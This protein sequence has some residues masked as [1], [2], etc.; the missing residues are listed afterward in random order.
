MP[1]V[2]NIANQPD[3]NNHAF[4]ITPNL[5]YSDTGNIYFKFERGF[6]SASPTQLTNSVRPQGATRGLVYKFNDLKS[7]ILNT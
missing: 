1:T 6:Y 5:K 2:K 4:E 7:E 3:T